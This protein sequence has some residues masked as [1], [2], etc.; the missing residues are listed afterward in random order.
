M[1]MLQVIFDEYLEI[2][3]SESRVRRRPEV[4]RLMRTSSRV[5]LRCAD[6]EAERRR[7]ELGRHKSSEPGVLLDGPREARLPPFLVMFFFR[8]RTGRGISMTNAT[9]V[10]GCIEPFTNTAAVDSSVAVA[11]SGTVWEATHRRIT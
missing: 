5:P 3:P 1:R 8:L 10:L 7:D 9:R 11:P 2:R 4:Q 6:D